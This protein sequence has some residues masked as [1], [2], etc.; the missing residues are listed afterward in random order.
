MEL[1]E[2]LCVVCPSGTSS[3]K[4]SQSSSLSQVYLMSGSGL[5]QV[6]FRS[7][8]GLL[9]LSLSAFFTYFV[10]PT[11]PKILRLIGIGLRTKLSIFS[12]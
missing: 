1:K 2:S 11:E 5:S 8:S 3:V 4:I 10:G 12:G 6:F 7:V 9:R